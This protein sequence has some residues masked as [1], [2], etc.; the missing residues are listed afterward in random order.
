MSLLL[1]LVL[2]KHTFRL[3]QMAACGKLRRTS[4]LLCA[5]PE[6]LPVIK[7]RRMSLLLCLLFKSERL[8]DVKC[9]LG[10]PPYRFRTDVP[11]NSYTFE[12]GVVG[13]ALGLACLGLP[14][15]ALA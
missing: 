10:P 9:A 7:N 14:W 13:C 5:F 1:C 3:R 2:R 6:L 15:L 11:A 8:A 4:Q 12:R